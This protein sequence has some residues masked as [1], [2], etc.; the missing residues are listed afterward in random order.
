MSHCLKL[1][2]LPLV[3][4]ILL[5]VQTISSPARSSDALDATETKTPETTIETPTPALSSSASIPQFQLELPPSKEKTA[6]NMM[7]REERREINSDLPVMHFW[8]NVKGK[9][10]LDSRTPSNGIGIL[11]DKNAKYAPNMYSGA[12]ISG[13]WRGFSASATSTATVMVNGSIINCGPSLSP[14]IIAQERQA[15]YDDD[16]LAASGKSAIAHIELSGS[17]IFWGPEKSGNFLEPLSRLMDFWLTREP[18]RHR[19]YLKG[20]VRLTADYIRFDGPVSRIGTDVSLNARRIVVNGIDLP[21][22]AWREALTQM[23]N[24]AAQPGNQ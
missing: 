1:P 10:Q 9:P 23:Q 6:I 24:S 16:A 8:T 5:S 7:R 21:P 11:F 3:G 12:N 22:E 13:A 15:M 18:I 14:K 17:G 2:A 4:V 19:S 20:P